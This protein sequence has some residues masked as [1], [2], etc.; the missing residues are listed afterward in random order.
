M[1]TIQITSDRLT[2]EQVTIAVE[3]MKADGYVVLRDAIPVE[4]IN[5]LRERA[6][7][8]IE[9]LK[10]RKD[11]PFNWNAGNLQQD[12]A[13]FPPY[14]FRE[15]LA[16][17]YAIQVTSSI[18]GKGMV[19]AFYSGNT[20]LPSDQR[21]PVHA[22]MGHL[23]PNQEQVHPP[24]AIVVNVPLVDVSEV[25]GSTEIWPG[26][27]CDPTIVLQDGEIEVP[28]SQ[29]EK[30]RAIAPPIQ[31]AMTAGSILIRDMRLWHAGTPNRTSVPR[32]MIAMI[33]YA[34]WWPT[35]KFALDVSAEAMLS[36]PQLR[37]NADYVTGAIDHISSPGGYA[38]LDEA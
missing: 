16:N 33:H 20:A 18:L 36:H 10:A 29:L 38:Y 30:W 2:D 1:T 28:E 5:V 15:V 22:D 11:R 35:G 13:P 32:P 3:A 37:Q 19:N 9:A 24:Y 6:F 27:H 7:A 23:W 34:A 26:T 4:I 21:Q 8:D 12:P 31:P 17:D 14:L 25:N